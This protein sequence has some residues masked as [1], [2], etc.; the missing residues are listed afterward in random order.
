MASKTTS[1]QHVTESAVLASEI[2]QL[3]DL[4]GFLKFASQPNW[5]RVKLSV[6]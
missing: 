6:C 5:R 2:E 3:V 4:E 1:H